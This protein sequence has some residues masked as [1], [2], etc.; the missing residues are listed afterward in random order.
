MGGVIPA[1]LV[2]FAFGK[3]LHPATAATFD[4]PVAVAPQTAW[5]GARLSYSGSGTWHVPA[6]VPPGTYMV[7]ATG[8]VFGCAWY[9]LSKDDGKPRSEIEAGSVNRGSFSVFTV[10]STDKLV[11]FRGECAWALTE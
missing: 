3:N 4:S 9:R 2:G 8:N 1:A 11:R 6:Q 10:A 5:A 7:T